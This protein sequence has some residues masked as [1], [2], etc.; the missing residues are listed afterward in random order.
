MAIVGV[1]GFINWNT[2]NCS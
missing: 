2:M 1:N